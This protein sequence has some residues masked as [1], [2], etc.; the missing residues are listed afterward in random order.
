MVKIYSYVTIA[1]ISY[2]FCKLKKRICFSKTTFTKLAV[3]TLTY[4]FYN[5]KEEK[6]F[7]YFTLLGLRQKKRYQIV[8]VYRYPR[9]LVLYHFYWLL[10]H[11]TNK[12][13]ALLCIKMELKLS[14]LRSAIN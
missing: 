5:F 11:T 3:K 6:H 9:Y 10:L 8:Y 14:L 2:S 4:Y 13:Q 12:Q 7:L 1:T